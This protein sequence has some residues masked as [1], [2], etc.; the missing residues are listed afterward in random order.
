MVTYRSVKAV[1]YSNQIAVEHFVPPAVVLTA[2]SADVAEAVVGP[3]VVVV[4]VAC[5]RSEVPI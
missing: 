2:V 1:V 3:A 4:V 5:R